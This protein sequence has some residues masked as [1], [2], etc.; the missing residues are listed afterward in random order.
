MYTFVIILIVLIVINIALILISTK[1]IERKT[2]VTKSE[3][4]STSLSRI[5]RE[6]FNSFEKHDVLPKGSS[7]A[8][9]ALQSSQKEALP[10]SKKERITPPQD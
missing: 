3:S 10:T 7:K 5:Y 2:N 4:T 8:Q 9:N 6:A 1:A